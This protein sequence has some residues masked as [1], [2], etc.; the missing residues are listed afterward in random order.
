MSRLNPEKLHLELLPGTQPSGPV[1]PRF[2]TLTHS[3]ATGDLHPTV[4]AEHDRRQI[5]AWHT[6]LMRDEVLAEWGEGEGKPS[7]HV[8]CHVS[9]GLLVGAAKWRDAIFR[10]ELPFVLEALRFGDRALFE[11]HPE[12]D[13]APVWVHFGS[14]DPKYDRTERWGAIGDYSRQGTSGSEPI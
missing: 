7:L 8:H 14:S 13:H 11:A 9:G 3:D 4:G 6:L 1:V 5:S 12:L 10:R 2:Y